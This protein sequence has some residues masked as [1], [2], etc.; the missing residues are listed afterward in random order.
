MAEI[1]RSYFQD[2]FE[3]GEKGHYEH[4]LTGIERRQGLNFLSSTSE[5]RYDVSPIST[6]HIVL[7][8][9]KVN[10]INLSH[11]RPISLC[12]VIYK[13]MANDIANHF[14]GVL[15]KC[16]D[17]AQSAFVPG[18]LISDNVLLAYEILHTLKR[19]KFR[20]KKGLMAVKLDM[21]KAYDRVE[22]T[23]V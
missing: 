9:K 23:F 5:R 12:N 13:I 22:W 8:P 11:F 18:R 4:L 16:I 3:A 19:K 6:T 14:K 10:P 15:E 7:S 2:L 20:K 1:A 21:N 17:D